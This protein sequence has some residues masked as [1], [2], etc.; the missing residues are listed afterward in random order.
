MKTARGES[1]RI[2]LTKRVLQVVG[3]KIVPK[4]D[5]VT[6]EENVLLISV[7]GVYLVQIH[8]LKEYK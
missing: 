8:T 7:L 5:S 6:T 2:G 3:G 1:R 4:I